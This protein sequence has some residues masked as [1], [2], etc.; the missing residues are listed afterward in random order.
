[1][2]IFV[3][4]WFIQAAFS[5]AA[6]TPSPSP[7]TVAPAEVAAAAPLVLTAEQEA[8][9]QQFILDSQMNTEWS[10]K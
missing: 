4:S 6:P 7:V 8:M 1:M 3:A 10:L 9:V 5:S 2:C